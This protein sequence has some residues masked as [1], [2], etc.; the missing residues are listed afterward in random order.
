[1]RGKP[2]R[3]PRHARWLLADVCG[4]PDARPANPFGSLP[5]L[6]RGGGGGGFEVVRIPAGFLARP[7]GEGD[8]VVRI[9]AGPLARRRR[10]RRSRSDPCRSSG[11][12][13]GARATKSFGSLPVLWRGGGARATKSFGSLPV[14]WLARRRSAG[15]RARRGYRQGSERFQGGG[16]LRRAMGTGR[17]P[18]DSAGRCPPPR[19]ADRQGSERFQGLEGPRRAARTGRDPND[20]PGSARQ[21]F[22]FRMPTSAWAAARRAIVTRK[23]EH[24]T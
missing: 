3:S 10:R 20:F 15:L 7:R 22:V 9:P 6:W 13:A 24:D 17:D 11:G 1:M 5:V 14:F 12:A 19:G 2:P 21:L 16:A 8:K 23:G 18:N 4:D